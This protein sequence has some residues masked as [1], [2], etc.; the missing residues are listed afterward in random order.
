MCVRVVHAWRYVVTSFLCT[1]IY[2][3]SCMYLYNHRPGDQENLVSVDRWSSYRGVSVY[4]RL[5]IGYFN[6]GHLE[7]VVFM[8][9]GGLYYKCP[10]T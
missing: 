1:H 8:Y 2:S 7:Q 3:E 4:L 6:G 5:C 10:C 9:R